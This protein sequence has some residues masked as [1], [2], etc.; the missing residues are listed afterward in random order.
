MF[1]EGFPEPV[2]GSLKPDRSRPGLGITFRRTD[3]EPYRQH[4]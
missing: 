1:F 3:A 2:N 4:F